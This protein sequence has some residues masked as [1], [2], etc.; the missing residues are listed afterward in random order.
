MLLLQ[1]PSAHND[2][3]SILQSKRLRVVL[4]TGHRLQDN[5]RLHLVEP[6]DQVWTGPYRSKSR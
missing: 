6:H 1:A 5:E 2:V 3:F 4:A